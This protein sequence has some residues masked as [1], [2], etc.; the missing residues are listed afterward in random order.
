MP[1]RKPTALK[2]LSG[3]LRPSRVNVNEPQPPPGAKPPPWLPRGGPAR[4]AWNRLAPELTAVGVLKSTDADALALV[5]MAMA[6]YQEAITD[7]VGWRRS[8]AAAKR[9]AVLLR[10]FGLT[11]A[12][13]GRVEAVQLPANDPLAEW[14][15]SGTVTLPPPPRPRKPAKPAADPLQAWLD[16]KESS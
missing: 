15:A 1:A 14:M 16:D 6:E 8:D 7:P 13:R 9:L 2:V 10:D 3:T 5:C 11:P 12:T 4:K